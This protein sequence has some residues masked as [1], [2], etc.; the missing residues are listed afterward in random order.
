MSARYYVDAWVAPGV[1]VDFGEARTFGGMV[2]LAREI[3]R[4]YPRATLAF[5]NIDRC[6]ID[7]NGLTDEEREILC[8]LAI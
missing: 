3:R 4:E 6:D 7:D 5:G 1:Q 8:D 2:V